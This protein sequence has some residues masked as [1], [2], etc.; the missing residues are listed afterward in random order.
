[1]LILEKSC[2]RMSV[3]WFLGTCGK[4][5]TRD[6]DELECLD[7]L[8]QELMLKTQLQ[9]YNTALQV[10]LLTWLAQSKHAFLLIAFDFASMTLLHV[11]SHQ[12]P[13]FMKLR[14]IVNTGIDHDMTSLPPYLPLV[15]ILPHCFPHTLPTS[16]NFHLLLEV[17]GRFS[18]CRDA[19][20]EKPAFIPA[21]SI[22]H[23]LSLQS[24][25]RA[26]RCLS[27]T[28]LIVQSLRSVAAST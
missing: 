15:P 6:S 17:K 7:S 27:C 24:K 10:L 2:S 5:H 9:M 4:R 12:S 21:P 28:L 20:L 16:K 3:F 8:L 23:K 26:L 25:I 18:F 19:F 11:G 22:Q 1:M 14:D 13:C